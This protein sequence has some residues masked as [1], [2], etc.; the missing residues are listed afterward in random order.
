MIGNTISHYRILEKLGGGGTPSRWEAW[1]RESNRLST[2]SSPV[3]TIRRS[4]LDC[5]GVDRDLPCPGVL[6]LPRWCAPRPAQP[7]QADSCLRAS[8]S[9]VEPAGQIRLRSR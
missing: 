5:A 9:A 3:G 8:A 2:D 1:G 7:K 4:P 6:Q